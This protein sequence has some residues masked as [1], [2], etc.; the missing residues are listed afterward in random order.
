MLIQ[1]LAAQFT[2]LARE[3]QLQLAAVSYAGDVLL[4]IFLAKVFVHIIIQYET[5]A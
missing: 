2:E 1:P 3:R 4:P 5:E